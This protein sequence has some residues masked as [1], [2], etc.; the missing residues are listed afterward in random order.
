MQNAD[1]L[2][3]FEG[4]KSRVMNLVQDHKTPLCLIYYD[5]LRH[6]TPN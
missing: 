4:K 3:Y 6:E 2:K 5:Y 1:D